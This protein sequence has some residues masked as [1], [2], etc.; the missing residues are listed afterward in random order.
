MNIIDDYSLD[1]WDFNKKA[2]FGY[3]T[4][5]SYCGTCSHSNGPSN[6]SHILCFHPK[7]RLA[8]AVTQYK[9]TKKKICNAYRGE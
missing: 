1:Y 3:A 2:F 4:T 6:P 8:Y 7:R 9:R 5:S